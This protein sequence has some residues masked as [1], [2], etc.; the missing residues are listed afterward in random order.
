MPN[1]QK[2]TQIIA[3][4]NIVSAL[5][6][7]ILTGLAILIFYP[8]YARGLYFDKEL[9]PFHIMS[10]SLFILFWIYK[11]L[12]KDYAVFKTPLDYAAAGMVV[13]YFLPIVFTQAANM[14]MAVGELLKYCNYFAIYLIIRDTVK[15]KKE[16]YTLLN[17]IVASAVGIALVGIDSAAGEK[18]ARVVENIVNVLPGVNYK[19]FGGYTSGRITSMIQYANTL[20]SYLLAAFI[21]STGLT[22]YT[23]NKFLKHI[24]TG[25]SFILLLTFIFTYS[26]GAWL[27]F[28]AVYIL[29]IILLRDVY[30]AIEGMLYSGIAGTLT[31]GAVPFFY[32]FVNAKDVAGIWKITIGGAVL[33][34]ILSFAIG[35]LVEFLKKFRRKHLVIAGTVFIAI[36]LISIGSLIGL[37]LNIEKPV[38]LSHTQ[39]EKDGT[40]T[41]GKVVDGIQSNV[42]YT[43]KYDIEF[44]SP[45][46]KKW[47]YKL[48]IDS[49]NAEKKTQNI[50]EATNIDL[51]NNKEITFKTLED[52]EKI[53]IKIQNHYANTYVKLQNVT[54]TNHANNQQK[55]VIFRYKYIPDTIVAR[56]NDINTETQ[57]VTERAVFYKDS[58]KIIKD[59][60]VLGA[61]GGGWAALNFMYQSYM[62]WSTQAHNYF[63]Q[64]WIETGTLGLLVLLSFVG[65]LLFTIYRFKTQNREA[66][67]NS[68]LVATLAAAV[69]SLLAHSA[70]DFD[71]SLAAV[72]LM[73]WELIACLILITKDLFEIK[74]YTLKRYRYEIAGAGIVSAA[75]LFA[76]ISLQSGYANAQAAVQKVKQND[77]KSAVKYFEKAVKQDPFTASYKIDLAKLYNNLSVKEKDGKKQVVNQEQFENAEKMVQKALKLEP[78]NSQLYAHAA[79]IAMGRGK[80]EEGLKYIDKAIQVQPLRAQNYQQKADV[81]FQ[82]GVNNLN[83]KKYNEAEKAFKEVLNIPVVMKEI[84]K[85]ILKPISLTPETMEYIE[86]SDWLLRNYKDPESV[87]KF[88]RLVFSAYMDADTN[89]DGL[90]D[91]WWSWKNKGSQLQINII[92][93]NAIRIANTGNVEG[94]VLTRKF[95]L[96]P[97][98]KYMLEMKIKGELESDKTFEVFI[99]SEKGEQVQFRANILR[100]NLSWEK[101]YFEF[102]TTKD[103]KD[104]KQFIRFDHN[105]NDKGYVEISDIMLYQLD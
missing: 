103:I 16:L 54:L 19:I 81:Y 55:K 41:V 43:L 57:S 66:G 60:P 44:D 48:I 4:L 9:L 22:I 12:N 50:V 5:R 80:I 37:A 76:V 98:K 99:I 75:I 15:N 84:N 11:F 32:K 20:A 68:I 87:K 3:Q 90:P 100:P 21:L 59:R 10:F 65:L 2:K 79:S 58:L 14:R 53:N 24:Y 92:N 93:E 85:K 13:V 26:R 47:A 38:E 34:V 83:A 6:T 91:S 77:L 62:Y 7:I 17:I 27:L 25:A 70:I 96:Q 97:Q 35:F 42:E 52:T 18:A 23:K 95:S 39:S 36:T 101:H 51:Q 86:R 78:Y 94:I 73:L 40:K 72:S 74:H 45:D 69:L 56:I 61:G 1:V 71:L 82:I 46:E 29:F 63:I 33:A 8:P 102:I 30:H 88:N 105:G 28:P 49:I 89:E 64:V 104:G 31:L 67:E